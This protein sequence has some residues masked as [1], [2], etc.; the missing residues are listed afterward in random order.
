MDDRGT[1]TMSGK[2]L[3]R[4]E[5]LGHVL[6]RHGKP[7]AFYSDQASIFRVN[8]SEARRTEGVTQFNRALSE[9]NIGG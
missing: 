8:A 4:L 6:E 7:V 5:V 1:L 2:E 9:L 3:N